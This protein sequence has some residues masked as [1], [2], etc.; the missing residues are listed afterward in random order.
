[1]TNNKKKILIIE[2]E[3]TI[4]LMYQTKFMQD[5]FI[6]LTANNGIQG[7][8]MA[9]KEKPDLI[10][11]DIIMPELDGFAVL[12]QLRASQ[13]TKNIPIILLTVLSAEEHRIRGEKLGATDYLIK[14][15]FTPAQVCKTIKKHI[16]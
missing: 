4:S 6:V 1:M 15:N 9:I 3:Q 5:G 12:Q 10:V 14:S 2:D 8:K 11:L 7:L 13:D 16:K